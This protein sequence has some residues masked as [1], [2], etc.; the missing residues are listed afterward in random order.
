GQFSEALSIFTDHRQRLW[1]GTTQFRIAEAH[2]AGHRPAQAARHAEQALALD[3][4][5]GDRMRGNV[6]TLLGHA[7][8]E[9][10]QT[11]RARA[12]WREALGIYQAY[13][14]SEALLVRTL[15]PPT[16]RA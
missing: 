15:L 12:C 13:G 3:C 8:A 9:L 2:R 14:A 6:L 11:D 7:L 4:I 16:G 1:E 10:G 5:G